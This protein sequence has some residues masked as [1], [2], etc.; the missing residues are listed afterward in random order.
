EII[1]L[2]PL[3]T[4]LG[5]RK[6]RLTGGEPTIREHIVELVRQIAS[7]EEVED[8]AMTTNGIL[9]KHLA[10]PLAEAGLQRINIS[11]D[12]LNP[13]KF[14]QITRWGNVDDAWAGIKAAEKAGLAVKLNAVIVRDMNDCEDVIDIARL[15]IDHAW[16]IRYIEVMPLGS[17]AAYQQSHIVT[18][19][20]LVAT[21]E[22]QLGS[23]TLMNGG[24][25]D[26]EARIYRLEGAKGTLGFI[27]SVTKPFCAGCNRARLT[28]DGRLRLCLLRDKEL[29][30]LALMR[31]GAT[32][33]ELLKLIEDSIW[34]KPWGHG[35]AEQ[36]FPHKRLMSEIGG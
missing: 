2:V 15:S 5:F 4:K 19:K 20:E 35:L 7:F 21:I 16:Q 17:I 25:L 9:L 24:E 12:T 33:E 28:P 22:A 32:D 6:I 29:D 1:R 10:A 27:S 3:F 18:E 14:K 23:L 13:E 30:L 26:G 34:F 36:I 8:L 31:G 11:I